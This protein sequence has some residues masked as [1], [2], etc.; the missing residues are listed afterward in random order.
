MSI[1]SAE[2]ICVGTELLMGQTLN[3]NSRFLARE[4]ASLGIPSYGSF[5]NPPL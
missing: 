3:T 4:L 5:Q 2:I 1:K